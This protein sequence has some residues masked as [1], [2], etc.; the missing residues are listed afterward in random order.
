MGRFLV[1]IYALGLV[2]IFTLITSRVYLHV[3][4]VENDVPY[5]MFS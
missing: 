3:H 2:F 5:L 1:Y 4:V